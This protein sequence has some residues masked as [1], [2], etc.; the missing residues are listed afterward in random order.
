MTVTTTD[1]GTLL[2][3]RSRKLRAT[4]YSVR[5]RCRAMQL[6]SIELRARAWRLR[7]QFYGAVYAFALGA[8][9]VDPHRRQEAVTAAVAC[10]ERWRRFVAVLPGLAMAEG[11][12][13]S[14]QGLLDWYDVVCED[15]GHQTLPPV[16][17][18]DSLLALGR[19]AP[20]S[21]SPSLA[22]ANGAVH[23]AK[24]LTECRRALDAPD[25]APVV[26]DHSLFELEVVTQASSQRYDELAYRL[27][28][29]G[30]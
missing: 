3:E 6:R 5:T 12:R 19:R 22:V 11:D 2:L 29:D 28:D 4:T 9:T 16:D 14:L 26:A 13:R 8:D 30:S 23:L 17:G 10:L 18:I 21:V 24:R 20:S 27:A 15:D 25:G 7:R 1:E